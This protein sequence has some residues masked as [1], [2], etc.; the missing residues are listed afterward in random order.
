MEHLNASSF[1]RADCAINYK[2]AKVALPVE[3]LEIFKR[4]FPALPSDLP[5][6]NS[7]KIKTITQKK[8][9]LSASGPNP[10]LRH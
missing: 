2:L 10:S 9:K 3:E 8:G 4:N 6:V 5:L 1:S 7:V